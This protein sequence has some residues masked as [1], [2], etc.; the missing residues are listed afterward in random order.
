MELAGRLSNPAFL[1]KLSRLLESVPATRGLHRKTSGSACIEV[2]A[3]VPG[4]LL[5]S[6][7]DRSSAAALKRAENTEIPANPRASTRFQPLVAE[8]CA[9][10]GGSSK[11]LEIRNF[12]VAAD[13]KR[14]S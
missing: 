10:Y 5:I 3:S 8:M 7:G 1:R 12:T 11:Q 4:H 14:W 9:D 2:R 13:S 6:T